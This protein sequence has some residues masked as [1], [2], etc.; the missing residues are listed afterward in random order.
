MIK[1]TGTFPDIFKH[2]VINSVYSMEINGGPISVKAIELE[3]EKIIEITHEDMGVDI[4]GE[5]K[6][7]ELDGG[8]YFADR[9]K[10]GGLN[11]VLAQKIV[12]DHKGTFE[13]QSNGGHGTKFVIHLPIDFTKI[14]Q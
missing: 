12:S 7:K 5:I 9:G 10:L 11:L 1:G 6:D 3:N 2:L 13:I 4:S 8:G 14:A